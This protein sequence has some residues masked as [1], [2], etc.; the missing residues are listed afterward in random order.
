[1]LRVPY[2]T[3]L[4]AAGATPTQTKG[5]AALAPLT[6]L[7]VLAVKLKTASALLRLSFVFS[8]FGWFHR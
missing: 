3:F 2:H 5:M 6:Q 8:K 7:L 1:M 4:R